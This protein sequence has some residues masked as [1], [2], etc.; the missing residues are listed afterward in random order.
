MQ[1]DRGY[2]EVRK[3]L[4]ERYGQLYKI[5]IVYVDCVINGQLICIE[6]GFVLQKFLILF[7]S[8]R[9]MLQEIGY[10][11]CLENLEGLRKIVDWLFYLFRLKWCELVDVIMQK[12]VRD[13]NLKDIIDFVEVR[14]RVI[15]YFIFGKI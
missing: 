4:V 14:L 3:L 8:C 15:N 12:E 11:N 2:K 5:V 13:F 1:E 10:L 6:D 7:I 9:N